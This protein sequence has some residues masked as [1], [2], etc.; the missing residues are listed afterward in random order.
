MKTKPSVFFLASAA[1][2]VLLI[3]GSAAL[4]YYSQKAVGALQQQLAARRTE[5]AATYER[6]PFPSDENVRGEDAAAASLRE[7]YGK[8]IEHA[9][10]GQLEL[11]ERSPSTFMKMLGDT[12][13]Q[14][15]GTIK[16]PGRVPKEFA[17]GFDR[18]FGEGVKLPSPEHVPRLTQQLKIVDGLARVLFEENITR[19]RATQ[20]EGFEGGDDSADL[21]DEEG[22]RRASLSNPAA[23]LV[24][25]GALYGKFHFILEFDARESALLGVVNRLTRHDLFTVVTRIEI[26]KN[27]DD[28]HAIT[29]KDATPDE[30]AA[31]STAVPGSPPGRPALPAAPLSREER[32][33]S[34]VALETPM[35]VTLELDVYN[36]PGGGT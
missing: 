11:E 24:P 26:K 27:A 7:W 14:L 1:V 31:E 25:P 22:V 35:T 8:L 3:G 16:D 2:A 29:R 21:A 9:R 5:L 4:L 32:L 19:L 23:G 10:H 18:Y 20:R 30:D 12:Q 6:N 13:R 17:F 36:F 34:G 15:M 28:V 33:V